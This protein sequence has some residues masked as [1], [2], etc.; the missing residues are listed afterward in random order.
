MVETVTH[1][2]FYQMW[3][4]AY[5]EKFEAEELIFSRGSLGE[6]TKEIIDAIKTN[7]PIDS[8]S[9]QDIDL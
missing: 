9:A 1:E 8:L 7:T 3:L 4:K 2:E 6:H 5:L